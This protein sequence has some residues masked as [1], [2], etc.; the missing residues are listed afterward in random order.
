MSSCDHELLFTASS[1]HAKTV[2]YKD[3]TPK[4]LL[5]AAHPSGRA[6]KHQE[7]PSDSTFPAPLVLPGDDL[8]LDPEY[9]PQSLKSWINEPHRNEVTVR[10]R[11]LY[12][13]PVPAVSKTVAFVDAWARPGKE[14]AKS[15]IDSPKADDVVQ[16]LQAFYHGL[17]V[18][19]LSKPRLQFMS[20]NETPQE[21]PETGRKY[22]GLNIGSQII[23][24]RS[25]PSKDKVF[26]GQLNLNDLLDAAM[27]MLPKDAYAL[28][29]LVD[30]DLYEDEEDDFCCGRA[31]GGSR[32]SVVSTA[33][34]NPA[35]DDAQE[36]ER[37]HP[38]PASHCRDYV[39]MCCQEAHEAP[40]KLAMKPTSPDSSPLGEAV[41]AFQSL[42][43][44]TAAA[45]FRN[46]WLG[47]LCKTAS[48]ELGHCFGMDHCVYYAC[49][50]QG[51]TGLT[52]DAGQ[53]PY[54]CPV[55]L[56]KV[57]TATGSDEAT[58]AR[59]MLKFCERFSNDRMFIAF[60]AWLKGR[61]LEIEGIDA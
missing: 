57:L 22:I 37:E 20:W 1:I 26:S 48:H 19:L 25:R 14:H 58:W 5:A 43:V 13:V 61:L 36:V 11:A 47:R 46:L 32:V 41:S 55:D 51:T 53:P 42:P 27:T 6:P 45:E 33:R 28:L 35:L 59:S 39:D 30:H 4:Q 31:Y 60:A 40:M 15:S 3:P 12:V 23:G 52:E 7:P 21:D 50:M 8:A 29:M 44:P 38:W 54:L 49:I 16:Y 10:R 34:Y 17:P 56:A 9:E 24:I 2:G 18:K